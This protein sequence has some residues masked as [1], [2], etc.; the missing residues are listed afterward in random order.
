MS[1]ATTFQVDISPQRADT[2][3]IAKCI[4]ESLDALIGFDA[5]VHILQKDDTTL[6]IVIIEKVR[7][8]L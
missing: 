8:S 4:K 6:D 5:G 1:K 3:T 7:L 2:E